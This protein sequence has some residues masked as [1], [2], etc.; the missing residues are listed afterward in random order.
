MIPIKK[1]IDINAHIINMNCEIYVENDLVKAIIS[2]D[3]LGYGVITAIKFNAT[4]Y[5]SFGD[6]VSINGKNQFF[7]IIQD[8]FIDRNSSANNLIANMPDKDIRKLNLEE[9]Q[10]CYDDGSVVTYSGKEELV[11]ETQKYDTTLENEEEALDVLRDVLSDKIKYLPIESDKGW[12]CSCGRY[13]DKS[14]IHCSLCNLSKNDIFKLYDSTFLETA[15][16]QH[17]QNE[18]KRDEQNKIINKQKQRKHILIG[19]ASL[20]IIALLIVIAVNVRRAIILS[21]RTIFSSEDSMKSELQG[22]YT[23]YDNSGKPSRQI[24][25]KDDSLIYHYQY[26][27]DLEVNIKTWDYENGI[28]KTFSELV[29]TKEGNIKDGDSIY[30]KGG[31]MTKSSNTT[32]TFTSNDYESGYSVLKISTDSVTFNSGYTICTGSVKNTGSKTYSYI[33]VK[34]SFKNFSGTVI[35]TDWTYAAGSEGLSPGE[36]TTFRLSVPKNREISSCSVSLMGFQ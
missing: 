2:F 24:I 7:L 9:F 5:N 16:E 20:L 36:S 19:I 11:F 6:I 34:G 31:Y 1:T 26:S 13:N 23:Y 4:G 15:Y 17:M 18:E 27:D 10:I 12:L 21:E 35:D 8:I 25:I 33:N 14:N 3:N 22:T 29:V 30:R 32:S 28:I